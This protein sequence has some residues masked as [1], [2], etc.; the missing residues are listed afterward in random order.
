MSGSHPERLIPANTTL[1]QPGARYFRLVDAL[2]ILDSTAA[3]GSLQTQLTTQGTNVSSNAANITTLTANVTTLQTQVTTLQATATGLQN[4][5]N[6]LEAQIV[7]LTN[8]IN[9]YNGVGPIP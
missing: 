3:L 6:A 5:I 9:A 8:R 1:L 7:A 2:Q 4:Q